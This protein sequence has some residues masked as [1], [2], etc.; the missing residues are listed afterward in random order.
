MHL[1]EDELVVHAYGE[2]RQEDETAVDAHLAACPE[3]RSLW[4]EITATLHMA[5]SAAVP[6]PAA[7][8]EQR[9]WERVHRGIGAAEYRL[10][11]SSEHRFL[12]GPI[13]RWLAP[14]AGLAAAIAI[15][16]LA[17]RMWHQPSAPSPVVASVPA[18]ADPAGQE[19]VL[20]TALDDHFQR[21]EMLLVELM[22]ARGASGRDLAF[23]RETAG[24]LVDSG[25][26][27]QQTAQQ[28]GNFRLAA[29]LEDLESVLV[30]VANSPERM[31]A[32]DLR[33]LRTRID[34]D[35][36]L[37]KVRAVS[38]QIQTREKSLTT[39]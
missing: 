36:L 34:D 39:E 32:Q 13:S 5:D 27:Y 35:N 6:E 9:M 10:V 3:C 17:G 15:A 21:S 4:E 22:N 37:F 24:D 31:E 12:G 30:E 19:R 7:D 38:K 20:L 26:L 14:A 16:V 23:E 29:M 18:A 28:H 33:S 8:F 2:G 1:T 11:D 25:R